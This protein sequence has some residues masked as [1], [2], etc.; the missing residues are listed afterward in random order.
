VE[1]RADEGKKREGLCRYISRPAISKKPLSLTANGSIRY[2]VKT[3]YRD[4]T[5][6]AIFVPLYLIARLAAL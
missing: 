6:R 5:T 4:G 1:A 3:H 2:Q